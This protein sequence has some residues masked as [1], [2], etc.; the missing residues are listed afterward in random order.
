MQECAPLNPAVLGS[1]ILGAIGTASYSCR[2]KS[3]H[4]QLL[5]DDW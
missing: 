1:E 2:H 3:Q 4:R 5:G